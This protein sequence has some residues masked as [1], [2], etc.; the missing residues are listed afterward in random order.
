MGLRTLRTSF[1]K[2]GAEGPPPPRVI[3]VLP[4]HGADRVNELLLAYGTAPIILP[5]QLSY[6]KEL[7]KCPLID[8]PPLKK[9]YVLG[10]V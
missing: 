2:G 1:L 3:P 6:R 10:K 7:T 4:E 5:F 9:E 8:Y